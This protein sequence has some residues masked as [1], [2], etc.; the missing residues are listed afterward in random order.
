M[1]HDGADVIYI[2]KAAR[3][4][5]R[6]ALGSRGLAVVEPWLDVCVVVAEDGQL[7][8]VFHRKQRLKHP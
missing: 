7:V 3:K 5:L 6:A 1:R 8:T 2:D 4:R